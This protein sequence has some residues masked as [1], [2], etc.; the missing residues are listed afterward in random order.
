MYRYNFILISKIGK[1]INF[2]MSLN[3]YKSSTYL[4]IASNECTRNTDKCDIMVN[5]KRN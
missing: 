4:S 1:R 2:S 3:I 5:K